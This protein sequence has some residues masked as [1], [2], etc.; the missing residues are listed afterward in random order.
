MRTLRAFVL[1]LAF[2]GAVFASNL[3][4]KI[5]DPQSAM[6]GSARVSLYRKGETKPSAIRL[7]SGDGQL[8]L[9]GLERGSYRIQVLAPG[10]APESQDVEVGQESS[11]ILH[12]KL[13]SV[14][15]TVTVTAAATPATGSQTASDVST[16]GA[17]TIQTLQP[18]AMGEIL[19]FAPGAIVSDT[20]QRGGLTS[21]FVRGGD[22]DYNKVIIDGVPVNEPGGT[23]DFGVVS[24]TEVDRIELLRGAESTLYGSDAMTST[25]QVFSRNGTTQVP[26]LTLGSD[27]GTFESAHGYGSFSGAVRKFDYNLFGEQFNT[28]GQGMNDEFSNSTEGANVGYAFTP[29]IQLRLRVRHS[30][31]RVGDQGAWNFSDGVALPAGDSNLP[32]DSNAFSRQNNFLG[33]TELGI[34]TGRWYHR[35]SG[36]EYSHQRLDEQDPPLNPLRVSAFGY[37][38]DYVDY[39]ASFTQIPSQGWADYNR[40]GFSYQGEYWARDWA[41]TVVGYEF[42]DENGFFGDLNDLPINHGLRRNHAVYGEELLT[43]R[44]FSL[45]A[46]ARYVHNE[47]FGNR[48]VPRAAVSYMLLKG[49]EIFSGTRLRGSYSEGVKEP[50]F[51]D[52]FGEAVYNILANPNLKPE[53][54]RAFE[55]GLNQSFVGGKYSFDATYFNNQF[56]DQIE[57]QIVNPAT[58]AG[59]FINLNRSIAHGAELTFNGRPSAHINVQGAY[60]YTSTQIL[61]APLAADPWTLPGQPLLRRPKHSGNLLVGYTRKR[62]GVTLGGAFVGRRPDSDFYVLPVPLTHDAGYARFDAGVWYAVNRYLTGYANAENLLNRQYEDALGYPGLGANFRAGMRFTIGG[63]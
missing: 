47:S 19:R 29:K 11:L 63:E 37:P 16:V 28:N 40:A 50:S 42:E 62:Y 23:F 25:V 48:G 58:Y 6:V 33:S 15:E 52:T 8:E 34:T 22:S 41:R 32:P 27:G 56:H 5:V 59:D 45:Q 39:D 4:I 12:L 9:R 1:L 14:S 60:V 26:L 44:R 43:W 30:T 55:A 17:E 13:A 24:T 10:F 54:T 61:S 20:G 51:E 36:Y 3:K 18:V 49:G 38:I 31:N 35:F 46:G 7:A 2:T 53:Q 57:F 21:L